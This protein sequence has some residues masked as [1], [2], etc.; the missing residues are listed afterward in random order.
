MREY[1]RFK[2]VGK[3]LRRK[4]SA[5]HPIKVCPVCLHDHLKTQINPFLGL[6]TA[7]IYFCENCGYRGSIYAEIDLDEYIQHFNLDE[8][9]NE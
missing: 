2:K 9:E 4:P 7:P 8:K 6:L 5:P 3:L 1:F